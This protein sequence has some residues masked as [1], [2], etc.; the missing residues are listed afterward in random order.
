MP[1][2]SGEPYD[3]SVTSHKVKMNCGFVEPMETSADFGWYGSWKNSATPI[4]FDDARVNTC[5]RHDLRNSP[6]P[7]KTFEHHNLLSAPVSVLGMPRVDA[8]RKS[9]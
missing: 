5:Y 4:D 1:E 6:V 9:V 2:L 7:E 3:L 8:N